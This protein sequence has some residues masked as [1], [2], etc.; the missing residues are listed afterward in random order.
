MISIVD[1][2]MGNL[3]S[4]ENALDF[5]GIKSVI[6]SERE[7]ILNSDGIILPGVGA[8]PDAINNIKREGIDKVLKE[9]VKKDKSLLGICLGMQL[10][11]EESEEIKSCR[12]LGFL[13]GKIEKMKVNLKIPHMGW[14]NLSFC[15][16]SPILKGI[17]QR[18]YVYYV[19]SYY[20][21]IEE[22]GILNAYSQYGIEV[23]GIVSKNNI[24]GIQFHPE[25]SGDIGLKILSNFGELIK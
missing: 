10:L 17:K 6:T 11:F 20:A 19:H 8:F 9:A 13:K 4:V 14:N 22:E 5:L 25:K 24:Y 23:P 18:S 3:K 1:Y 15:K 2:G 21:K 16:D 12:G 7:V